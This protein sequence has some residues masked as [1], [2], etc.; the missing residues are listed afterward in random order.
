MPTP[1]P[2]PRYAD[3]GER[4]AATLIDASLLFAVAMAV[5]LLTGFARSLDGVPGFAWLAGAAFFAWLN[6]SKGQSPGKALTGIKLV[7]DSDGT[8]LGGPV[9]L[10]R[11]LVLALLSGLTGGLFYVVSVLWPLWDPKRQTL[12]DKIV[13]ASAV[14]GQPRARFSK[15]I[16][17]P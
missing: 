1:S 6:G 2:G 9:G 14:P 12:H 3:W 10:V 15:A 5:G 13:G 16:F 7:R 4:A 11:A 17:R 8:T